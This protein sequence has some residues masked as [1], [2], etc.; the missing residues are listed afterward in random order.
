[1]TPRFQDWEHVSSETK[2]MGKST[3]E[4]CLVDEKCDCEC[5]LKLKL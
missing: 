1:M 4:E 3:E 2:K 5:V